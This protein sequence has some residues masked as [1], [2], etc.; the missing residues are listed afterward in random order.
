MKTSDYAIN[1]IYSILAEATGIAMYKLTKPSK[2]NSSEFIVINSLPIG[3]GVLQKCHINVNYHV[4]DMAPGVPDLTKLENGTLQFMAVLE[5][6]SET[7]LHIDFESQEYFREHELNNH[8]S[9][10]RLSVKL[11]N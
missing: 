2:V 10:I 7:G 6:V 1:Q 3:P 8:Y 5:E 11:I 4:A 9:N